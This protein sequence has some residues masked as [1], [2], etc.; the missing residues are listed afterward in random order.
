LRLGTLRF[1]HDTRVHSA[2]V[3]PD[4]KVIAAGGGGRVVLWDAATG[5][6]LRRL[7]LPP[8]GVTPLAFS[9]NGRT[10]AT[11][12]GDNLVRLWDAAS[13]KLLRQLVGH[14]GP[15]DPR[16]YTLPGLYHIAFSPDGKTLASRGSDRTVRLWEVA[17]GRQLHRFDAPPLL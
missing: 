10:L 2:A 17:T 6:Q 3:S 4:G 15:P 11:G 7:D 14:E 12:S 13:G 9:P 1:R 5:K 16:Y 8:T